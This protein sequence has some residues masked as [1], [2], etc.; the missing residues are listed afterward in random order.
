MSRPEFIEVQKA[1]SGMSYPATK[2]Q[3]IR[4]AQEHGAGED[5]LNALRALPE[6][7]YDGP[8]EVSAAV[9]HV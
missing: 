5:I 4:H 8:N 9:A 3:L 7:Q 2:D 6:K 1:L